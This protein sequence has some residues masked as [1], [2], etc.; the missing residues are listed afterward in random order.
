[1]PLA[2]KRKQSVGS[3]PIA[4]SNFQAYLLSLLASFLV[5]IPS[6]LHHL[7]CYLIGCYQ[8]IFNDQKPLISMI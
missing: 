7:I 4:D 3:F 2:L 8:T 6:F 5:Q 1:M